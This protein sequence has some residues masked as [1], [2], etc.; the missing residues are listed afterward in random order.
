MG[1]RAIWWGA[2]QDR[3]VPLPHNVLELQELQELQECSTAWLL[4]LSKVRSFF[5]QFLWQQAQVSVCKLLYTNSE[6]FPWLHALLIRAFQ[7]PKRL[8][9]SGP[10]VSWLF[11]KIV[12]LV[13][14][15][16]FF[17]NVCKILNSWWLVD[18]FDYRPFLPVLNFSFF[19]LLRHDIIL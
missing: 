14:V 13:K 1:L 7:Y 8:L 19:F 2:F 5:Q 12:I 15:F 18:I 10:A 17:F 3:W 9:L 6:K 4:L 11:K 16:W